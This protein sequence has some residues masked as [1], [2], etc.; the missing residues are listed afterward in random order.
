M[1]GKY[2][3]RRGGRRV[4][5]GRKKSTDPIVTYHVHITSAQAS[6]LKKWGAG[7]I[8][9]GLRWLVE[10]ASVLIQKIK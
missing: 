3:E 4:G 2:V 10:A 9:A 5:S 7:D 1:S 8:S 6:L